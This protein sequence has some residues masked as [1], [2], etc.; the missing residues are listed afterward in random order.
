MREIYERMREHM[1]RYEQSRRTIGIST[2]DVVAQ[3]YTQ[4]ELRQLVEGLR[5][6][7]PS[8][9]ATFRLWSF[10]YERQEGRIPEE[11]RRDAADHLASYL[12]DCEDPLDNEA[13]QIFAVWGRHRSDYRS[14][15]EPLLGHP[16][17]HIRSTALSF[18]PCY[19]PRRSLDVLFNFRRDPFV[20]ETG[21]MGGPLRYVLRDQALAILEKL[22]ECPKVLAG[23]CFEDTD[24]GRASYRTWVPFLNWYE[25]N[26][27]RL[28]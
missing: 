4:A 23:D 17:A 21:G 20:C 9:D 18:A 25:K 11:L 6:H 3:E 5:L 24:N 8:G 22:T 26:K 10:I 28:R 19:I 16:A 2:G 1:E 15:C 7:P 14:V 27:K 13:V 12:D